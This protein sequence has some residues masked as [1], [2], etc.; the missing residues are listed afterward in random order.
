M[1]M[2]ES[3]PPDLSL[4]WLFTRLRFRHSMYPE[5]MHYEFN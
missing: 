5:N 2:M 3:Y 4:P 1:G